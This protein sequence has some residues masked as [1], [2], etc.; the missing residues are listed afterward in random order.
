[1]NICCDS[2][3]T[4]PNKNYSFNLKT[5]SAGIYTDVHQDNM[6]RYKLQKGV[7]FKDGYLCMLDG[8]ATIKIWI[9]VFNTLSVIECVNNGFV[10]VI[11]C[12]TRYVTFR[13]NGKELLRYDKGNLLVDNCEGEIKLDINKLCRLYK[14][15]NFTELPVIHESLSVHNTILADPTY[16]ELHELL[17]KMN[18]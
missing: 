9:S 7:C 16:R 18:R 17:L 15:E 2:L 8:A 12:I 6:P 11:N 1:M 13:K 5:N 3:F 4:D 10:L 14:P